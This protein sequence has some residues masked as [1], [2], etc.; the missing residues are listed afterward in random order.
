MSKQLRHKQ[1]SQIIVIAPIALLAFAGMLGVVVEIGLSKLIQSEMQN[2]ADAA[3]LASVWY[4]PDAPCSSSDNRCAIDNAQVT[5]AALPDNSPS[6]A[7]NKVARDYVQA[8]GQLATTLCGAPLDVSPQPGNLKVPRVNAIT[9]VVSC[10][11]GFFGA[12]LFGLLP[13]EIWAAGTA[14]I[15]SDDAT[16][17]IVAPRSPGPG[18]KFVGRLV[19]QT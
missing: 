10:Q 2:A 5:T 18:E 17:N 3:A 13:R 7:A 16:G 14:A 19:Q 9:V 11:A 12:Q 4:G 8:N 6:A 1:R 15:G